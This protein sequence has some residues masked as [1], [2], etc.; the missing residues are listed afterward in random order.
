MTEKRTD[1]RVKYTLM[2]IRQ[3]FVKLLKQK[4]ISKITIKEICDEADI[5]RATFYAHYVDQYDLL[6]QLESDIV[7]DINQYL[8]RY[9]LK[10][11]AEVPTEMLEKILDYIKKNADLFRLLL[12]NTN[13]DIQFQREITNIIGQQHFS[14]PSADNEDSEYMYLF[15]ANGVIGVVLKWLE[16][17]TQ[18]PVKEMTALIMNLAVNG[19]GFLQNHSL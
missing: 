1:R 13:A 6:H 4:P 12:L 14:L 5:N 17:G 16:D 11:M 8:G 9:D 19:S 7:A 10:N 15:F 18:K 3:S 2:V